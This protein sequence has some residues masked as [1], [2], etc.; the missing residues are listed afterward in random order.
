MGATLVSRF[1][2]MNYILHSSMVT[3]KTGNTLRIVIIQGD[4]NSVRS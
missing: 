4:E 2:N 3:L 1:T